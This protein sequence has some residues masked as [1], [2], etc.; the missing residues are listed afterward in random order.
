[1]CA[2]GAVA[3]MVLRSVEC[4]VES[5]RANTG[6]YICRSSDVFSEG[7]GYAHAAG[8]RKSRRAMV[9]DMLSQHHTRIIGVEVQVR[10]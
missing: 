9:V 2:G 10:D 8:L 5:A 7:T 3:L 1:M 6:A 4:I